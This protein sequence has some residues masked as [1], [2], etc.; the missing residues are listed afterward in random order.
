MDKASAAGSDDC[1]KAPEEG[2]TEE[3]ENAVAIFRARV[4]VLHELGV[5]LEDADVST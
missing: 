4:S 3:E 1:N 2:N 5:H